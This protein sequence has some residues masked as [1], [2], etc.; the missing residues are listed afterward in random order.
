M[1]EGKNRCIKCYRGI[2]SLN[3]YVYII[4]KEGF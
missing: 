1:G 2:C 3:D 4:N